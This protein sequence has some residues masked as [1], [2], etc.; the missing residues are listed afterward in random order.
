MPTTFTLRPANFDDMDA[1]MAIGHEGLRPHI[2]AFKTWDDDVEEAGFRQHFVPEQIEIIQASGAD[3]GYIKIEH[4][5]D[6]HYIDGIYIAKAYRGTGIGTQVLKAKLQELSDLPIRLRVYKTN[7]AQYLYARL[8]FNE[9][10]STDE[11]L[12]MEYQ[13]NNG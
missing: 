1:M 7:P 2:E 10:R 13:P 8:G 3:A 11:A 5:G 6:H 9:V 12:I 4:R